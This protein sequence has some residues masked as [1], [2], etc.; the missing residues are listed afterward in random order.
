MH[1]NRKGVAARIQCVVETPA[2]ACRLVAAGHGLNRGCLREELIVSAYRWLASASIGLLSFVAVGQDAR[3]AGVPAGT[4]IQNTAEVSYT[5]GGNT[6]TTPSNTVGITVDEILDVV[7]TLQSGSVSV[8]PGATNQELLF[9]VTN[10]GNGPERFRLD[11]T[12]VLTG[13]DF[14]PVPATT[15]IYFDTDNSGDLSPADV[16]YDF[17]GTNEPIL[18]P[19]TFINVFVVNDIPAPL[20]NGARGRS[21]LQAYARTGTGVP[22]TS[23]AG[24]GVGGTT[25]VVGT[26]GA[27]ADATGE[28]IV[29]DIS[30]AAVKSQ[31]VVDQFGGARPVPGARINYRIVVT[32]TGTGTA[33]AAAFRDN[34]PANTTYVAG[35]LRLNAAT[36]TDASDTDAGAYVTTPAPQV[37]VQ[38]G[39]LTQAS[40]PQTVEFAVVIN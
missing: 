39:N 27:D 9:R 12:S 40:G 29:S 6:A 10:T 32:A 23:F 28:Y 7:V 19:D 30:L 8:T 38:L 20:A 25:A 17:G 34:I 4:T 18:A 11:M 14:D 5:I 26:T 33:T 2:L 13:D 22:G 21:Q 15:R 36:L 3:A 35:T 16:A 24:Q 1:C 37:Q 31:T